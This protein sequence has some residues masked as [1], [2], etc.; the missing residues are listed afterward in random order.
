MEKNFSY[1]RGVNPADPP[2]GAEPANRNHYMAKRINVKLFDEIVLENVAIAVCFLL[3]WIL[4][5]TVFGL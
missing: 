4:L 2:S 5:E 3:L 1:I